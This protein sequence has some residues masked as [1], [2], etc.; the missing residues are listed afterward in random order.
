MSFVFQMV[1][2]FID[3]IIPISWLKQF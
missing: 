1:K 3:C 2:P